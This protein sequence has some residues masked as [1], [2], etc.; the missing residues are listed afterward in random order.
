MAMTR[1]NLMCLAA[2]AALSCGRRKSPL[3]GRLLYGDVAR[4]A[5]MGEHRTATPADVQTSEWLR[6]E[7]ESAGYRTRLTTF[8]LEQFFPRKTELTVAGTLLPSFPMWWPRPTGPGPLRGAL[9][10]EIALVKLGEVRGG[11]IA[12][13]DPVHQALESAIRAGAAGIVAIVSSFSG[14]PATLNVRP[15]DARWPVPIVVAGEDDCP[16]LDRWAAQRA[17]ASLL[18]D[19]AY[20]KEAAAH[21]VIGRL[22]RGRRFVMVTTPSS[23]WFRCAGERGP[24]IALWLALA[25]WAKT[26]S[27]VSYQFVASSGHE[28]DGMGLRAFLRSEPP[29]VEDI[30]CWLHLGA[31]IATYDYRRAPDGLHKLTLPSP[32]RRLYSSARLAP[33]VR[34]AFTMVP[35]LTPVTDRPLGEMI[36][37]AEKEYPYFGFAGG[38]VFHHTPGDLP[39]RA[40]GPEL[41][42]P[43]GAAVVNAL[44]AI[45][46]SLGG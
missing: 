23:G 41:L 2:G 18:V 3:D 33:V 30:I 14:E 28:L 39:E 19:G 36:L 32:Q 24:G 15:D 16:R 27:R 37:M 38:S 5:S 31:G 4:Y 8:Q 21:D 17:D 22:E 44:T 25:R 1:R 46:S 13:G 43:V 35:D 9:G 42:G 20:R 29:R 34:N 11:A 12:P 6:Q 26:K 40:T 7:L 45:E 10:K